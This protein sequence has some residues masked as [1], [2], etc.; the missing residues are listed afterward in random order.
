MSAPDG[1]VYLD[2]HAG[3]LAAPTSAAR[4]RRQLAADQAVRARAER[5]GDPHGA[6]H[7]DRQRALSPSAVAAL[8]PDDAE[9][10]EAVVRG[11][12]VSVVF[13]LPAGRSGRVL[14]PWSAE[15]EAA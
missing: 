10:R 11:D 4:T 14:L 12:H 7:L 2:Q 15:L 13:L 6:V 5:L 3:E 1:P 9:L 8:L